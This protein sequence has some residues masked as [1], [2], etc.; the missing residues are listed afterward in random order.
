[1]R[2]PLLLVSNKVLFPGSFLKINVGK[3]DSVRLV[4]SVFKS[5]K[6]G[7]RNNSVVI[8]TICPEEEEK[9]EGETLS[10]EENGGETVLTSISVTRSSGKKVKAYSVG[11]LGTVMNVLVPMA[12]KSSKPPRYKYTLVIRGDQRVNIERVGENRDGV[13]LAQVTGFQSFDDPTRRDSSDRRALALSIKEQ[14]QKL[15][16]MVHS[17]LLTKSQIILKYRKT[18]SQI[19]FLSTGTSGA[20]LTNCKNERT[21]RC[22][23]HK[24]T[25]GACG[26][27]DVGTL[28]FDKGKAES[29]GDIE[30]GRASQSYAASSYETSRCD[31]TLSR[32]ECQSEW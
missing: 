14:F 28:S 12:L 4:E 8:S 21:C 26:S 15:I 9:K 23:E 16:K 20:K 1:M 10:S 3:E 30:C 13:K 27:R 22:S 6:P 5:G 17:Y 18:F 25:R 32:V 19:Q 29:S 7:P 11:V 2:A 31:A 24:K